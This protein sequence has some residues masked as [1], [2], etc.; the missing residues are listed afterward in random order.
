MGSQATKISTLPT[1]IVRSELRY[2][3]SPVAPKSLSVSRR[4]LVDKAVDKGG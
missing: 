4:D 2:A 1:F 3:D